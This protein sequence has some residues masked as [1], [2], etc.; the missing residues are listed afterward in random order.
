MAYKRV[1]TVNVYV[2]VCVSET[3][4]TVK[5]CQIHLLFASVLILSSHPSD[6]L[7]CSQKSVLQPT[8]QTHHNYGFLLHFLKCVF[9]CPVAFLLLDYLRQSHQTL[10]WLKKWKFC[11]SQESGIVL[12]GFPEWL[13]KWFMVTLHWKFD[14]CFFWMIY[15]EPYTAF[16]SLCRRLS[17]TA[18]SSPREPA[19]V[20][21]NLRWV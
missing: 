20:V 8:Y 21:E 2:Q 15:W 16:L 5:I 11:H 6:R 13:S 3:E 17:G 14:V 10:N 19:S 1:C 4:S 18:M 12:F 9:M 7:V